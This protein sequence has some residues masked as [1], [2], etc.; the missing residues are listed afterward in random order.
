MYWSYLFLALTHQYGIEI[1]K[2]TEVMLWKP[3]SLL[4]DRWANGQMDGKME[5]YDESSICPHQLHWM[6]CNEV[7]DAYIDIQQIAQYR[8]LNIYI[9]G[10][11]TGSGGVCCPNARG[12]VRNR[13]SNPK[14]VSRRDLRYCSYKP[15]CIGT[16]NPDRPVL[17]TIITW[18]FQFHPMNISNLN[19]KGAYML[20]ARAV[21]CTPPIV[22]SRGAS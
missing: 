7:H 18:H 10:I 12:H 9:S 20:E 16:T 6:G 21:S 14:G 3:C 8:V 11:K 13:K 5:G 15:E 17:I 2:Q 22:T 1:P 4:T 19:V